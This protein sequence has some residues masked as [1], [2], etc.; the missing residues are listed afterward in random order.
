LGFQIITAARGRD[1]DRFLFGSAP[2]ERLP[3][4]PPHAHSLHAIELLG[5]P[6]AKLAITPL[7]SGLEE[8]MREVRVKE[9]VRISER[10]EMYEVRLVRKDGRGFAC[11]GYTSVHQIGRYFVLTLDG[12]VSRLYITVS[13][14]APRN[15]ALLEQL[16]FRPNN[17]TIY[18]IA[19]NPF[20]YRPLD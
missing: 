6:L 4:V 11:N 8:E 19:M 16:Y 12:R 14:L 15:I 2:T 3:T 1:L 17:L 5:P 10:G 20:N 13:F 9:L 18:S 7:Y